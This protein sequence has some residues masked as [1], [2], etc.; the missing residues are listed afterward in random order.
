VKEA[1]QAVLSAL[2]S[3]KGRGAS[4]M[5]VTN[6]ELLNVAVEVLE[7]DGGVPGAAPVTLSSQELNYLSCF[8]W[9]LAV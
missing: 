3:V 6:Q 8:G 4:G 7:R 9:Q 1:E 5:D 2:G